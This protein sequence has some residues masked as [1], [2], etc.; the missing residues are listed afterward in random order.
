MGANASGW[1]RGRVGVKALPC[2]TLMDSAMSLHTFFHCLVVL[3]S[4]MALIA[5][6]DLYLSRK[7]SFSPLHRA[8]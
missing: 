4:A 3:V 5:A 6:W 2:V 8:A 7:Q 1:E